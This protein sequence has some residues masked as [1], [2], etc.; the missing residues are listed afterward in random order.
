MSSSFFIAFEGTEG[1]GKSTQ[2]RLL[3]DRLRLSGRVVTVNQEPGGTAIGKDIR[4]ILLDPANAEM[5]AKTELL[6]MF[7]SRA[8]AAAETIL[9]ALQRHEIVVSD[10]FTDSSLA[11]QGAGRE[12]GFETVWALHQLA[13]GMLLPDLTICLSVDVESGLARAARRNR[14]SGGPVSEARIDEQALEFHYRV[15]AAY[16]HIAQT[17]PHRF[18]LVNGEGSIDEVAARVWQTLQGL[19]RL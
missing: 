1:S 14:D 7:A 6:L 9:P 16:E 13:L 17:E 2:M 3:V 5:A 10:R 15:A 11:Y 8:Q 4:R 18:V 19:R 12:L